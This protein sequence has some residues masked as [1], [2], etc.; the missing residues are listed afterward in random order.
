MTL[1]ELKSALS[2]QKHLSI[3]DA[4]GF[5]MRPHFHLTEIGLNT[6]KFVDCGG[7]YREESKASFQLWYGPDIDHRLSVE[8]LLNIIQLG[9]D[10]LGLSNEEIEIEYQGQT[11]GKFSLQQTEL[12]FQL[13]NTQTAC[14]ALDACGIPA[15][16]TKIQ[17]SALYQ[18]ES[19]SCTPGGGCC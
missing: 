9:E 16:K 1:Q 12:G 17:L 11:I 7:T 4:S 15:E 14:L 18:N 19:N 13:T 2:E 5:P 6:K 8:K 3:Y 10:K